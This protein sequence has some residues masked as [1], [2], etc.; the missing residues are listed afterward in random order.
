[1]SPISVPVLFAGLITCLLLERLRWFCYGTELP[2][3]V[4]NVLKD[5]AAEEKMHRSV[6]DSAALFIQAIAALVLIFGLAF[7]IAEVGLIGLLVIIMVTALNGVTDDFF[8]QAEDGIRVLYVTGVQT[9]ALP[10]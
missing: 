3:S 2:T 8:F 5:F 1:M 6:N 4:L 7:H 10:I 9:C